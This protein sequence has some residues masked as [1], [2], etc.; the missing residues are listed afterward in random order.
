MAVPAER[1]RRMG[2]SLAASPDVALSIGIIGIL[3]VMVLPVPPWAIDIL[4]TVNIS[5]SVVVLLATIYLKR[6][7]EFSVF[8]SLLLVLTLYRLSL[9]VATTKLILAEAYGG[10]PRAAV[11]TYGAG[12]LAASVVAALILAGRKWDAANSA[13]CTG[14]RTNAC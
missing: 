11:W 4:L 7:V 12:W 10:Y 6:P 14:P 8:P 2:G 13:N 1:L 3:L 9:N 5:L